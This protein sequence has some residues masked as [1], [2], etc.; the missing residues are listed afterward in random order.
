MGRTTSRQGYYST[1][2]LSPSTAKE[3]HG[4]ISF[5]YLRWFDAIEPRASSM[6]IMEDQEDAMDGEDE[7]DREG[8]MMSR[9]SPIPTREFP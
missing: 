9:V 8:R 4:Q 6:A 3:Y 5:F 7:K 1:S 2:P